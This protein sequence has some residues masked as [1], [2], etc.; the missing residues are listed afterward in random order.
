[1]NPLQDEALSAVFTKNGTAKVDRGFGNRL[2]SQIQFDRNGDGKVDSQLTFDR[3]FW[4]GLK[5]IKVGNAS[6]PDQGGSASPDKTWAGRIN[7]SK[8]DLNK[9]GKTDVAVTVK[10]GFLSVDK[11]EID[12]N[13][14]GKADHL[15]TPDKSWTG[16][17]RGLH[18]DLNADGTNDGYVRF[19]RNFWGNI[20][21][22][23]FERAKK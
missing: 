20:D 4:S 19:E 5:S 18:V 16:T 12:V 2:A 21:K 9:D 14:D 3:S 8:F 23:H 7:E 15:M 6:Q 10:R 13:G 17:V 11:L 22:L 1:M